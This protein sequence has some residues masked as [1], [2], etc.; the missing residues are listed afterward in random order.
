VVQKAANLVLH[1]TLDT[2]EVPSDLSCGLA[3]SI[4]SSTNHFTN[5]ERREYPLIWPVAFLA[6]VSRVWCNGGSLGVTYQKSSVFGITE[7]ICHAT[8]SQ[9][10]NFGGCRQA[11][12]QSLIQL[13]KVY[14]TWPFRF[15]RASHGFNFPSISGVT[16]D[17]LSKR[18]W[19][20]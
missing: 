8:G 14:I 2:N 18:V 20:P 9:K 5:M 3:K 7:S 16:P 4:A 11:L 15:G 1:D 13:C 17:S 6:I 12:R 19:N 10:G